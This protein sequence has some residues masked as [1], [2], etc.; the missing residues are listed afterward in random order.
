VKILLYL[1]IALVDIRLT[2]I[3]VVLPGK[4]LSLTLLLLVLSLSLLDCRGRSRASPGHD[5]SPCQTLMHSL[6]A[7]QCG[8]RLGRVGCPLHRLIVR[9][10]PLAEKQDRRD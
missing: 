1:P 8:A 6:V 3:L 4:P 9:I 2:L 7:P 10:Q 5:G